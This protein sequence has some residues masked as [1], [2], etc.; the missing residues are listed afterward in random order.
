MQRCRASERAVLILHLTFLHLVWNLD[1]FQTLHSF[2]RL[3]LLCRRRRPIPFLFRQPPRLLSVCRILLGINPKPLA[4]ATTPK[5]ASSGFRMSYISLEHV[6]SIFSEFAALLIKTSR[7]CGQSGDRAFYWCHTEST[8]QNGRILILLCSL[9]ALLLMCPNWLTVICFAAEDKV[10][11]FCAVR[12]NVIQSFP[13]PPLVR[14]TFA[15]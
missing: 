6:Q 7:Q 10:S 15:F 14:G 13:V 1:S 2:A 3:Q 11:A 12:M 4:C 8:P 5:P 9:S